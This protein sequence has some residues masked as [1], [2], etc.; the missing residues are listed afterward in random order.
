MEEGAEETH[1]S[2]KSLTVIHE[3]NQY[4]KVCRNE[5][6]AEVFVE[7]SKGDIFWVKFDACVDVPE[8]GATTDKT[9]T[10]RAS[11]KNLDYHMIACKYFNQEHMTWNNIT[12]RVE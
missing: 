11:V 7:R 5:T 6:Q 8:E 3:R 12:G 4:L 9:K 1:L 2:G 10:I